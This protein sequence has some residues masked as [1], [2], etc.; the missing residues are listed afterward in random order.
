MTGRARTTNNSVAS[1]EEQS[2]L[3]SEVLNRKEL[4]TVSKLSDKERK[5][6]LKKKKE[7]MVKAKSQATPQGPAGTNVT[8][9]IT[10]PVTTAA[11]AAAGSDTPG[12]DKTPVTPVVPAV[13][14]D[15]VESEGEE[16]GYSWAD[17][18]AAQARAT[19]QYMQAPQYGNFVPN[20]SFG[21]GALPQWG[22]DW[23]H[24]TDQGRPVHAMSEAGSEIDSSE[25][26]PVLPITPQVPNIKSSGILGEFLQEQW[27]H[28]KESDRVTPKLDGDLALIFNKILKDSVFTSEMEKLAKSY[29]RI[30]NIEHMQVPKLDTEVFDVID[31]NIRNRD[32]SL[33]GIQKAIM[34]AVTAMAPTIKLAYERADTDEELNLLGRQLGESVKLL[35]YASN[36]ISTKRRD[37]IKPV[38]SPVYAKA[39]TKSHDTN[40]EWLFG[41]DLVTTT[42]KCEVSQKI[43]E[44][45]LKEKK[46]APVNQPQSQAKRFKG[47][48]GFPLLRAANPLHMQGVRFPSPQMFQPMMFPQQNMGFPTGF[49]RHYRPR[50]QFQSPQQGFPKRQNF[51]K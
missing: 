1:L 39:L 49:Q 6:F 29:P 5:K 51:P 7:E 26:I 41:G 16:I 48:R 14:D 46:K 9:A 38:L 40:P 44:K 28:V 23:S 15:S 10:T 50:N 24:F 32:Q 13:E 25:G 3:L 2:A 8:T 12:V 20:F 22:F 42:K 30:E 27:T 36:A 37:L 33:Q 43:S 21:L 19:A 4:E 35:G 31:Q 45:I 18:Q 34:A 11:A 17:I 47:P